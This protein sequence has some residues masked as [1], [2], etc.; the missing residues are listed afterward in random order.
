L[1]DRVALEAQREL[2]E[3][4]GAALGQRRAQAARGLEQ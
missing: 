3:P 4:A 2:I 1:R